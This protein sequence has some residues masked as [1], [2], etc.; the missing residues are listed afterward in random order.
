MAKL[1]FLI[2]LMTDDNDYQVEQAKVAE[3]TAL[4]LGIEHQIIYAENDAVT[5]STQI[6]RA[7]QSAPDQRPHAI[8]CEPVGATALPAVGRAA[9]NEG[10]GWAVLNRNVDY[11]GELRQTAK[12][13]AFCVSSDHLEVGRIQGRQCAALLPSGGTVLYLQG[14]SESSVAKERLLGMQEIKPANIHL[15]TLKGQWTGE[16]AM[17]AVKSWLQLSTS[18]KANIDLI[19]AQ[20]DAM[21]IGVRKAFQESADADRERWLERPFLGVDGVPKTGQAWVQSGLLTAT[22]FTP[23]NTAPAIE[24]FSDAFRTSRLPAQQVL[25]APSS[26]PALEKLKPRN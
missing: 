10:I 8:V 6:F 7:I 4:Q 20:N 24:L 26:I 1:R 11:I 17:R 2:S 25:I 3:A 16:S 15:I 13:P 14:P 18:R 21:A 9:V 5:Q 19:V 12:V 22:V 23:P